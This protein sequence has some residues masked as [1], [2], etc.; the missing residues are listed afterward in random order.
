LKTII[1]YQAPF[2]ILNIITGLIMTFSYFKRHNVVREVPPEVHS[3][4]KTARDFYEGIWPLLLII[5]LFFFF[6][7]PLHITLVGVA[8][9]LS[10][11]KRVNFREMAGLLFSKSSGRI[12]LLIAAV[13]VFQEMIEISNAFGYLTTMNVSVGM[14]VAIAFL[15]SF[16]MGFLTGVNTAF[17][18]IAYPILLPLIKNLGPEYFISMSI[19]VYVIGFAGILL[20]PLHLCL[21]LTSEYFKASLYKVFKYLIPP[22]IV[23]A[24]A[25]TIL[26]LIVK[27]H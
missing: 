14:V 11:I 13:M 19:Y 17:I 5:V 4:F 22:G 20:S 2:T 9:L 3:F 26:A 1:L 25:S 15:V 12:V 8:V 10:V 24:I 16:S 21:V 7:I 18:G 27:I 23:L 6:S